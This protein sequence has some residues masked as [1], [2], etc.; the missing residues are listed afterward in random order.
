MAR[1]GL[2]GGVAVQQADDAAR[3]RPELRAPGGI[4]V[5][6]LLLARR[7]FGPDA[8]NQPDRVLRVREVPRAER[9]V[10]MRWVDRVHTHGVGAHLRDQLDPP[11]IRAVVGG[12]LGGMFSGQRRADVDGLD[13][14]RPPCSA[15]VADLED[16]SSGTRGHVGRTWADTVRELRVGHRRRDARE[17]P[18]ARGIT[19]HDA[20]GAHEGRACS[21]QVAG[22]IGRH[23]AAG[24]CIVRLRRKRRRAVEQDARLRNGVPAHGDVRCAG[25][26]VGIAW[27]RAQ[28]VIERGLGRRDV[29][30]SVGGP[31][32]CQPRRRRRVE[33]LTLPRGSALPAGRSREREHHERE[34]GEVGWK[35]VQGAMRGRAEIHEKHATVEAICVPLLHRWSPCA[36]RWRREVR[37][38]W[39]AAPGSSRARPSSR[40]RSSAGPS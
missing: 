39:R 25:E 38:A 9:R 8:V 15:S 2:D 35:R 28:D 13:P 30:A 24:N 23:G 5:L 4:V 7:E 20:Q 3:F 26:R 33:R 6:L 12:K 32:A 37:A 27:A 31:A 22:A 21:R 1:Y 11:V 19:R 14:H 18:E 16:A 29:V 17:V 34:R 40:R 36:V 10:E